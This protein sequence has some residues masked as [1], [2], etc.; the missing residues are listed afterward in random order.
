MLFKCKMCG[1]DIEA[2]SDRTYGT[3]DSCG[4]TMT[5]PKEN[6]ER[7][8]HLFNRANHFRR[9]NEFDKAEAAYEALLSECE[10][11]AE[12]HWGVVLSRYGIEYVEDPISRKRIP[13]C[14]RTQ[15]QSILTDRDYKAAIE[16]APDGYTRSLYEEEAA[17]ISELQ[18]EILA[19]AVN[20]E[21]YDL[22]ICYKENSEAGTRTLDSVL[23]QDLYYQL[24]K[25]GFKVFYARISLEDKLGEKYEP[26]IFSALNS[27]KVMLVIGTKPEYFNGVWVKNEWHRF[28]K[29]LTESRDKLLIPC[30]KDMDA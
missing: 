10:K 20:E 5:L 13:T 2:S 11:S 24:V 15:F 9:C 29:F 18:K 7:L 8:A 27:A 22:F 26:Y 1:G 19:I 14:H 23:A 30:Y 12:A 28:L 21:P 6:D 3:C 17:Q 25:E 16:Y 4:S